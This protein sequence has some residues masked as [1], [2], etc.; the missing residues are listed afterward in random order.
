M[1]VRL[2][3]GRAA[4]TRLVPPRVFPFVR[5]CARELI[6]ILVSVKLTTDVPLPCIR[7]IDPNE[8]P[9]RDIRMVNG[10]IEYRDQPPPPQHHDR[11]G[12]NDE[13]I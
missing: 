12:L 8:V 6:I 13:A 2:R 5:A 10:V 9:D 3:S 1:L 11:I 4:D 7:L